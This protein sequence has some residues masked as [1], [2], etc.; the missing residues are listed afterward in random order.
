MLGHTYWCG[1]F[2]GA[3]NFKN[4]RVNGAGG[5]ATAGNRHGFDFIGG[6]SRQSVARLRPDGTVDPGFDHW[7]YTSSDY[8]KY[9]RLA[10]QAD[11]A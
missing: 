1:F 10:L 5:G 2:W 7:I 4:V 3:G 8:P 11:G 9:R 6:V